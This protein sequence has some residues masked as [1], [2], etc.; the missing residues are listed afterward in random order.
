MLVKFEA[1]GLL[2]VVPGLKK[3]AVSVETEDAVALAVEGATMGH[4]AYAESRCGVYEMMMGEDAR[5][6]SDEHRLIRQE[7]I[8]G[9]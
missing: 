2:S 4:A 5:D 1:K 6:G 3:K 9:L 7:L 8:M